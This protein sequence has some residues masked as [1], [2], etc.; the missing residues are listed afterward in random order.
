MYG[1]EQNNY[2]GDIPY[3]RAQL[4]FTQA[5]QTRHVKMM[6][7][8]ASLIDEENIKHSKPNF[9]Y[10]YCSLNINKVHIL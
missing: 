7:R 10:I 6:P 5:Q 9:T 3:Y 4:Q 2:K 8:G 1:V